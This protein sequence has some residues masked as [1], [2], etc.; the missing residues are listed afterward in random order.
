MGWEYRG[1]YGPYYIRRQTVHGYEIRQSYGR[2]PAA[3]QAARDDDLRRAA[4]ER[5]RAESSNLHRLDAE[6]SGLWQ[7]I[8]TL[9]QA[10]VL[11]AGYHQHHRGEWRRQ[12]HDDGS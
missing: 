4:Q 10:Y 9:M 5:H 6:A 8:Q 2:G 1:P 12:R 11:L 7:R 3:V